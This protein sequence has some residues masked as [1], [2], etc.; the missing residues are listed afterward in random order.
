MFFLRTSHQGDGVIIPLFKYTQYNP[1]AGLTTPRSYKQ[2]EESMG[3]GGD[4]ER[5]A[6]IASQIQNLKANS[7]LSWRVVKG[8]ADVPGSH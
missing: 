2:L 5:L 1:N 6:V 8:R 7:S 3:K 4:G